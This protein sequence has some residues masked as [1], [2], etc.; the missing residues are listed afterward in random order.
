MKKTKI[1][2]TKETVHLILEA[3]NIRTDSNGYVISTE[4]FDCVLDVDKN[5]FK[6]RDLIGIIGK[7]F[8]TRESQLIGL[9]L[10]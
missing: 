5:P 3:L 8:I 9:K 4:T 1:I 7:N 10:D 2:F 6:D